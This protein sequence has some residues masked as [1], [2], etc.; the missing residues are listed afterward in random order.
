MPMPE[1]LTPRE[2]R[3]A[4]A[5]E[6]AKLPAVDH[7]GRPVG[8]DHR[9]TVPVSTPEDIATAAQETRRRLGLITQENTQ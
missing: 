1:P 4:L 3:E 7:N 9:P 8:P 5:V 2:V 6:T